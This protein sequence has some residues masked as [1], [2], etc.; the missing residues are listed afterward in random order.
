MDGIGIIYGKNR[1]GEKKC[2]I[3]IEYKKNI[4]S[5]RNKIFHSDPARESREVIFVN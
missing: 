5:L 4:V 3:M 2:E 1:N